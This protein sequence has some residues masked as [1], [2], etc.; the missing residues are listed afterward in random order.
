VDQLDRGLARKLTLVCAP[1]GLG[2]T[3]V[4]ADWSQ[5]CAP[6]V[7]WLSLDA[8]D[9]DPVR[10]WRYIVAALDRV[11]PG[12]T[13]R[14]DPL[15]GSPGLASFEGLV[16]QVINELAAEPDELLRRGSGGVVTFG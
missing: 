5:Q 8:G 16:T 6:G 3:S 1:A 14:V 2:K 13:A 11:R 9:N 15:L 7:G 12:V 10:F 4:L